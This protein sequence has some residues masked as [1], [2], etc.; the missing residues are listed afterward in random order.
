MKSR[1]SRASM[2]LPLGL[3]DVIWRVVVWKRMDLPMLHRETKSALG[4][5]R[6]ARL[7]WLG[8]CRQ[9]GIGARATV[10]GFM[11]LSNLMACHRPA[12]GYCQSHDSNCVCCSETIP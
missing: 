5:A 6:L 3:K 2:D 8:L 11:P 12:R 1:N 10:E 4:L 9:V 7:L